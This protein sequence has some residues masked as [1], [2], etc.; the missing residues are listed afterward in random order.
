[1]TLS[2]EIQLAHTVDVKIS[3]PLAVGEQPGRP[4]IRTQELSL[5]VGA[6]ALPELSDPRV[7]AND[8]LVAHVV[9]RRPHAALIGNTVGYY[10]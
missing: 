4:S 10:A 6:S 9:V 8:K 2:S 7:I 1:L 5:G 3:T